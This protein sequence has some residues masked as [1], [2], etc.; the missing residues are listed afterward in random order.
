[1]NVFKDFWACPPWVD[2]SKPAGWTMYP[3][4]EYGKQATLKNISNPLAMFFRSPNVSWCLVAVV[5]YLYLP[6]TWDSNTSGGDVWSA[7]WLSKRFVMCFVLTFL[8]N[9]TWGWLLYW[10]PGFGSR[11][12]ANG[13][14]MSM[15]NII[16][17]MWYCTLA[18]VQWVIWEAVFV[19]L[20]AMGKLNFTPDAE[21]FASPKNAIVAL[22]WCIALP[23]W[24]SLQ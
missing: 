11:S 5:T 6:Y 23:I 8:Y 19:R 13:G 21:I 16:H 10:V 4:S 12:F 14:E 18:V 15:S 3:E 22:L 20:Y 2:Q 17:N 9:G 1:M 24:R 7:D